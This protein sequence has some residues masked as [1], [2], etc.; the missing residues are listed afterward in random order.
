[1][2]HAQ[3]SVLD[4]HPSIPLPSGAF[5]PLTDL[6]SCCLEVAE[7]PMPPRNS[8]PDEVLVCFGFNHT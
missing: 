4:I 6:G 7:A 5:T 3:F 8:A 1:M 2:T